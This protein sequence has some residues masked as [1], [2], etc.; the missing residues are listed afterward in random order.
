M[1][2]LPDVWVWDSWYMDDGERF[3][4]FYL[5]A[6]RALLD[7]ER[8]HTRPA[9]GHAVSTDLRNWTVVADA[10]V[11]EDAPAFDDQGIWSGSVMRDDSGG[12]HF[13]YT[14][15][16]RQT[17]MQVQRIGHAVSDDLMTWTRLGA[18]P[19]LTADPRWYETY[20]VCGREPWRDPWIVREGDGWRMLITAASSTGAL[21]Q[22]GCV[23][24]ATSPDLITWTAEAPLAEHVGLNQME[25]LQ[26]VEVDGR[27][28]IVFC[29]C[30]ADVHIPGA[31][32]KTGTWTAPA[33]SPTG[34]FHFDRAEPIDVEGN[35]AGRIVMDRAG[36]PNL[37]AFVD[38][39]PGQEL[40]GSLGNPVPLA[41]TERGTLQPVSAEAAAGFARG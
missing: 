29:L 14:G 36:T 28:V 17:V 6:S 23:G 34:P 18:E 10:L 32:R 7:P 35:Y 11:H 40:G 9:V 37:M 1:L 8:R 19:I 38:F 2:V 41:L 39:L 26:P 4:A 31:A 20:E 15:I 30:A 5:K 24:T 21:G 16:N 25:V 22:R 13:F 33:D 3:H 12:Y 27:H